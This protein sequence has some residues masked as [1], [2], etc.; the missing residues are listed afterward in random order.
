MIIRE[1]KKTDINSGL[2][3]T[4]QEV[5]SITEISENTINNFL[6]NDNY[7]YVAE[8]DD[9]KVI[10]SATLH[11]QKKIIRN[12][13]IAGFVE[14]VVVRK[15]YRNNNIGS[16]L[17]KK[18]IERSKELNCYK[19]VLSCFPERTSFYEKNGFFKESINMRNNLK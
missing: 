1:F 8:T 6:S 17:I 2:L 19:L 11:I 9:G 15:E 14:D 5:W 16:M 18:I 13:G 12:G 4:L 7:L 3:E 10:G